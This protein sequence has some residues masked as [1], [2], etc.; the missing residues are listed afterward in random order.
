[1]GGCYNCK[2]HK[3]KIVDFDENGK[4]IVSMNCLKGN[5]EKHSK[6]WDN[7]K[8]KSS[9]DDYDKLD[10]FDGHRSIKMLDNMLDS[11]NNLNEKI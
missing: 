5:N 8:H 9:N 7:N 3:S 2:Y 6:W 11:I 1:M 10:C 4:S